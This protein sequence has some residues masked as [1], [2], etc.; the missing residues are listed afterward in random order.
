MRLNP[1]NTDNIRVREGGG[2][3]RIPGGPAGGV[4]CG[5]IVLA[6]VAYFVFGADPMQTIGAIEGMQQTPST[7]RQSGRSEAEICNSG[8]YSQEACAALSS[9]NQT[10]EPEFQRAGIAFKDPMTMGVGKKLP[11][12]PLTE[13]NGIAV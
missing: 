13:T 8:S 3:G 2:R 1:F 12:Y 5:T 6:L 7:Q 11:H 4:G 10:W 9:L